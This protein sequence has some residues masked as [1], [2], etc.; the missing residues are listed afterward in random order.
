M[1][2]AERSQG[3]RA[4]LTI[5]LAA[6][7]G[8]LWLFLDAQGLGVPPFKRL[9]PTLLILA[10]AAA[11]ADYLALSR[12][13]SSAGWA[14]AWVGFGILGFALTLGWTK[15]TRILDWLPSFPTILG[16][17]FLVTWFAGPRKKDNLAIAGAVL[18][19]LGIMGFMARYDVLQR[20]L[21][22]AQVLWAVLLLLGG[23]YL[24]WRALVQARR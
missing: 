10:G 21:P 20:I 1:T 22:S 4:A 18:L 24:V 12:R 13:P 17:A 2:A 9:W 15:L 3:S 6:L 5:G 23:G 14:L 7:F 19:G 11:L 8:G 16:L